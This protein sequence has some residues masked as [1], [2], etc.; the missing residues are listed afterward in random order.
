MKINN[1][2]PD[3]ALFTFYWELMLPDIT[4]RKNLSMSHLLQFKVLCDAYCQYDILLEKVEDEGHTLSKITATGETI[5][6]NPVQK[7]LNTVINQ[8]QSY[9]KILGLILV[10]DAAPSNPKSPEEGEDHDDWC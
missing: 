2:K 4:G 10:K 1:P 3:N 9:S 7:Q 6:I 8:I 5:V